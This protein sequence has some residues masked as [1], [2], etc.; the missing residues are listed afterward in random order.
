MI[1]YRAHRSTAKVANREVLTVVLLSK[2][3]LLG[4]DAVAVGERFI[5]F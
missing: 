3:R 4:C 1:I 5:M 2:E